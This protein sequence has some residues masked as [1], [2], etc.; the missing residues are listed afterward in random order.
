MDIKSLMSKRSELLDQLSKY[1]EIMAPVEEEISQI[2]AEL[3]KQI[4]ESG[5]EKIT[6]AG[7]SSWIKQE[8]APKI[9]SWEEVYKFIVKNNAWDLLQKRVGITAFKDYVD[10]KGVVPDGM[11]VNSFKKISFKKVG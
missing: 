8:I 5:I 2:E 6:H 4:E 9:N 7:Y 3:F 11:E 1:K 10:K